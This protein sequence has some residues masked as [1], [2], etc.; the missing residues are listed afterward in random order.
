MLT[1][2]IFYSIARSSGCHGAA[3]LHEEVSPTSELRGVGINR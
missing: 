2:G 1:R 3:A